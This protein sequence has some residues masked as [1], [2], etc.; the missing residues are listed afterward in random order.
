MF[1]GKTP[2]VANAEPGDERRSIATQLTKYW[3]LS[4]IK[5]LDKSFRVDG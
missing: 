3:G 5:K 4:K 2:G 1:A